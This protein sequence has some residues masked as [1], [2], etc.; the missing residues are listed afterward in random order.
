MLLGFESNSLH[1]VTMELQCPAFFVY[2]FFFFSPSSNRSLCNEEKSCRVVVPQAGALLVLLGLFTPEL[3]L[4][5]SE[6]FFSAIIMYR[7]SCLIPTA[8]VSLFVPS[9]TP[10]N[11]S[12]LYNPFHPPIQRKNEH[13]P[14]QR[15]RTN[16]TR[17]I[18]I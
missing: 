8:V 1:I 9:A 2:F 12:T 10:L 5:I 11:L 14:G 4:P 15:R 6:G 3:L 13:L 16:D 17:S 7:L 18:S